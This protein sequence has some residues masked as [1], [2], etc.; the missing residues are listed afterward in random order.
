MKIF[1]IIL[2]VT[3]YS[4]IK[5]VNISPKT[6]KLLCEVCMSFVEDIRKN[7]ESTQLHIGH[8][9]FSQKFY[10]LAKESKLNSKV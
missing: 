10:S 7:P 4:A 3:F 9:S 6:S 5:A 2:L 1:T 8:F